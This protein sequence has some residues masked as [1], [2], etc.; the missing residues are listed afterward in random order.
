MTEVPFFKAGPAIQSLRE[1]DFDANSAFGEVIDNSIEAGAENINIK[2]ETS[3]RNGKT[4][5]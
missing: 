4:N 1:S 5:T 2:F 3:E